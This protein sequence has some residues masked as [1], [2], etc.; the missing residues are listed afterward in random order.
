LDTKRQL[1]EGRTPPKEGEGAKPARS[2][3][4]AE[5]FIHFCR[6]IMQKGSRKRQASQ[7]CEYSRNIHP[8]LE[9][10]N[11]KKEEEAKSEPE[12]RF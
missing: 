1:F 4:L 11:A 10:K 12:A 2:V 8:F 7:K 6:W 9:V 5:T 3:I